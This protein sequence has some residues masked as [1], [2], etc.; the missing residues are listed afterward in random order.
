[1]GGQITLSLK[2]KLLSYGRIVLSFCFIVMASFAFKEFDQ[3][4]KNE[5]KQQKYR[6]HFSI[7]L[8]LVQV[9]NHK[10]DMSMYNHCFVRF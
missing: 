10:F 9:S 3:K 7:I 1:M 8:G 5:R 6:P 2:Y 4:F